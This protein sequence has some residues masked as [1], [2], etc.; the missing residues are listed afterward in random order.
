MET[1]SSTVLFIQ[2]KDPAVPWSTVW[3]F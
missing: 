3:K 2:A 1:I